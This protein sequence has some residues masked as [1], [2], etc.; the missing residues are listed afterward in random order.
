MNPSNSHRGPMKSN[1]KGGRGG[2]AWRLVITGDILPF[3]FLPLPLSEM[4][5]GPS[6]VVVTDDGGFVGKT[7]NF[8]LKEEDI[9]DGLRFF[10]FVGAVTN[11]SL[12]ISRIGT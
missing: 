10:F 5:E 11:S 8:V 12:L 1:R 3:F 2:I 4:M 7:F 6:I 9:N